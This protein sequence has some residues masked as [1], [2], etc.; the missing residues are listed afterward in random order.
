LKA[1]LDTSVLI[2][3]LVTGHAAHERA[4]PWLRAA[5]NGEVSGVIALHTVAELY[6]VLTR[7]P[8]IGG[9]PVPEE[10]WD[11]IETEVLPYFEVVELALDDYRAVIEALVRDKRFGGII[12]DAVIAQAAIKS[13]AEQLVTLNAKDYLRTLPD[14][15]AEV[16][17][18]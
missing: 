15:A 8:A 11:L 14:F 10:V 4:F 12:Y 5:R 1:L 7:L 17:V 18:P 6:A 3:A 9:R 2:A 16:I 13:G